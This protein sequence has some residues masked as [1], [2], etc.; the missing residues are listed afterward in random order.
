[1][2][3]IDRAGGVKSPAPFGSAIPREV[4]LQWA[5]FFQE[6]L[7]FRPTDTKSKQ[8]PPGSLQGLQSYPKGHRLARYRRDQI[9]CGHRRHLVSCMLRR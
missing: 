6:K 7:Q 5:L 9:F 3:S 8:S 2:Y 4:P 1:M